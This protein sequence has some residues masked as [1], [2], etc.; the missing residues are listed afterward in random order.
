MNNDAD[1]QLFAEMRHALRQC[2]TV[3]GMRVSHLLVGPPMSG[4]FTYP[5]ANMWGFP[6]RPMQH[7]GVAAVA[8]KSHIPTS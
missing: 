5:G 4:L 2:I 3:N 1:L 8:Y 7:P 6:V